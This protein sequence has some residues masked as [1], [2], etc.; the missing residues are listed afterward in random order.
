[1]ANPEQ[2]QIVQQGPEAW[3]SWRQEVGDIDIDLSDADLIASDLRTANL[4]GANLRGAN[5]SRADLRG[6]NLSGANVRR[7][8]F[9]GANLFGA[10]LSHADLRQA[11]LSR[12]DLRTADV[13]RADF[14]GANLFDAG[15]SGVDLSEADLRGTTLP[16]GIDVPG[17]WFSKTANTVAEPVIQASIARLGIADTKNVQQ[18]AASQ[19]ELLTAYH[20]A[21]LGQSNRSF[22]WALIGSGI[23]LLL[24][25]FAV[26]IALLTGPSTSSLAS[27]VPLIAG[28]VV[29]VVSGIVFVLYGK[30][31]T[32]LSA[33]HSRL[34][35]LQRYLLANSICESLTER[36][37]DKARG[38]LIVVISRASTDTIGAVNGRAPGRRHRQTEDGK[39]GVMP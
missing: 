28:A 17:T 32:Q 6:A 3:N 34:E 37:R 22:Y 5:L 10:D 20:Q 21:A 12:A 33:F 9:T 7:A 29:N 13:R 27:I 23:G 39:V 26:G 31:S 4:R 8:D 38:A 18:I 1:M 11:N 16:R 25:I 30:T 19:L 35:E 15:L 2:L 24:F 14:S 36:E